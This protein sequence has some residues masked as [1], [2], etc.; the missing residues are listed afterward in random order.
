MLRSILSLPQAYDLF[1]NILGAHAFRRVFATEYIRP[2]RTERVL[3]IGCGPGSM[4]PYL[5]GTDYVGFDMSAAYIAAARKQFGD[6]A[7]FI[8]ERV[9]AKT[10]DAPGT[11]D[12]ALA[13]AIL[14]HLDD[15][16]AQKLFEI[17]TIALKPE[18][19]LVTQDPALVPGQNKF[20]R[21]MVSNDRGQ[22]V[23]AP[24]EYAAIARR[25][26]RDVKVHVRHDL[27]RIPYTH[28]IL[29]CT[30]PLTRLEH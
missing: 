27:L 10:I 15:A 22:H 1:Q 14:H 9:N 2:K 18:G 16:E 20:A 29:E 6:R 5:E 12:L 8:C 11:Y 7:T 23:R 4:F 17:A 25:S 28:V 21:W 13:S 19:R 26:F 3:D 24:A 30:K